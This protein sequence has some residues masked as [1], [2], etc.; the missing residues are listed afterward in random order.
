LLDIG[1]HLLTS[2][3]LAVASLAL[4]SPWV[5]TDGVTPIF[6]EKTDDLF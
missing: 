5:A 4:V 2:S 6:A 3:S 1:Y